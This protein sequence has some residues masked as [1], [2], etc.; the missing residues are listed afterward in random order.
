MTCRSVQSQTENTRSNTLAAMNEQQFQ[1]A[2]SAAQD[3]FGN[4]FQKV[5]FMFFD[6]KRTMEQMRGSYA[7]LTSA[8]DQ[9]LHHREQL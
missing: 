1:H 9:Y 8:V 4:D 6:L 3:R 7:S 5:E 2:Y